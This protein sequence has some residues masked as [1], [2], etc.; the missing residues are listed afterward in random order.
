MAP[1]GSPQPH[2][3]K[4]I[5]A[6]LHKRLVGRTLVIPLAN[7]TVDFKVTPSTQSIRFSL[8]TANPAEAKV[9]QAEALAYIEQY[10]EAVRNGR[11]IQLTLRQISALA[12]EFYKSWSSG[13]D[14]QR[15]NF[16]V[17]LLASLKV[18][19]LIGANQ[20]KEGKAMAFGHS[21]RPENLQAIGN[22]GLLLRRALP[23]EGM[24]SASVWL[25][26]LN[27]PAALRKY[28]AAPR[29]LI[30]VDDAGL[31]RDLL[32]EY[33]SVPSQFRKPGSGPDAYEYRG[34]IG[35]DLLR[36]HGDGDWGGIRAAQRSGLM[37]KFMRWLGRAW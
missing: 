7:D 31:N 19:S 25:F 14:A 21:T 32:R 12:G 13:P 23:V 27:D 3:V 15:L 36:I 9:R 18:L 17:C 4:R 10:L 1:K 2:F 6:D 33:Y 20:R 34:D 35:P 29:V 5:P 11:P 28:H 24:E 22:E 37:T 30:E 8:R 16:S 26:D